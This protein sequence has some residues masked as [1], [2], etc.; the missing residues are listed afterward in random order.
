MGEWIDVKIGELFTTTFPGEWG[1]EPTNSVQIPVIGTKNFKNN[2]KIKFDN[3]SYR[4]IPSSKLEK[5]RAIKGDILIEKSGGSPTQPAGRVVFIEDDFNGTS[6]NFVEVCK[7]NPKHFNVFVFYLLFYAYQTGKVLKYQQQTTGIINFKLREYKKD[8]LLK[9]PKSLSEQTT[10][11][12]ILTTINQ[13]IEKTEKLIVKYERI[14]IGLMQDLLTRGIDEQGRIRSEDTHEFKDSPLG[15]IPIEW[16][17]APFDSF[18]ELK[19]YGLSVSASENGVPLLRMNNLKNGELEISDLKFCPAPVSEQVI[20]NDLDLLFN[21]TNSIDY[22]GRTG[23]FRQQKIPF[24][25][26]SY[27]VRLVPKK[28]LMPEYLNYWMN[29]PKN[30][31]WIK[32]IATQA[33]HQANINPTNLGKLSVYVPKVEEQERIISIIDESKKGIVAMQKELS[34]LYLQKT[35]LMQDLLT[36]KVSVDGLNE[37]N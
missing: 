27:L 31:V 11:A 25:F 16:E 23:I 22:V 9:I 10:I 32:T 33:V 12:T 8:E 21:R 30:H 36:G 4:F 13:A 14:K 26:A 2:G 35:G 18:L 19:Q 28:N 1:K 17:V 37:N 20:L 15:R 7:V 29:F 6:S 3:I 34:K 24:T 5:V